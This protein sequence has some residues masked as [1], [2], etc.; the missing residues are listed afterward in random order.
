MKKEYIKVPGCAPVPFT[1]RLVEHYLIYAVPMKPTSSDY[2]PFTV[3]VWE[4]GNGTEKYPA[5]LHVSVVR[6]TPWDAYHDGA[7]YLW[8]K[9]AARR[10]LKKLIAKE[11]KSR[12]S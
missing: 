12:T 1:R 10:Y 6:T 3:S 11:F 7:R 5:I 2:F 8:E 4:K 9:P